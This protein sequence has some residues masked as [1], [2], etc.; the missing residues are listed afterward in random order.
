M[1]VDMAEES[2]TTVVGVR[3]TE[4]RRNRLEEHVENNGEYRSVPDLFRTAVTHEL[5][6][7]YGV[8]RDGASGSDSGGVSDETL[9]DMLRQLDEV[10]NELS[11]LRDDVDALSDEVRDGVP[12]DRMKRM[13]AIY[14]RL[15][16]N[17]AEA[18]DHEDVVDEFED[19]T[20]EH[21]WNALMQLYE[22]TA[23]VNQ[24]AQNEFWKED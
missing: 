18:M 11:A 7:D 2:E 24:T 14:A 8:I 22:D 12:G 9:V 6:D 21:A 15:P 5:S 17:E 1:N 16:S 23:S 10:T 20:K 3:V 4:S 19:M 13:N